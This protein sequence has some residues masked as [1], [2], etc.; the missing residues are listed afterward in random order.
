VQVKPTTT[1][2][3]APNAE[4]CHANVEQWAVAYIES[5]ELE[6]KLRPSA[7]PSNWSETAHRAPRLPGRP[8]ELRVL[9]AAPKLNAPKRSATARAKLV[10]TF[11]HHELQAAELMCWALVHFSDAPLAWRKGL[12]AICTDEIGHMGL[13]A[14][15]LSSVGHPVGSFPVRDWFW[16]RVPTCETPLQFV[17]LMSLGLEAA[18]LEHS[19]RFAHSF[20]EAG[21][22]AAAR[23]QE[24]VE[25]E[26]VAH[27]AF[28]RHWFEQLA[29][30]LTF[31]GWKA[32]LPQ[33]LSPLL[34]R[35]AQLNRS[36][37]R[38]AGMPESFLDALE[39]WQPDTPGSST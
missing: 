38:A 21:D 33:P 22:E 3:D 26:E 24:R 9:D 8:K 39:T 37:R 11:F 25:A 35:G 12:L 19:K 13:Y 2:R 32:Q 18:N 30:G 1:T 15:Y 34:M 4:P 10:H 29:G 16:E 6:Y 5:T 28:G 31:E 27:V 14:E 23:I 17:A 7:I 36:A 20:R